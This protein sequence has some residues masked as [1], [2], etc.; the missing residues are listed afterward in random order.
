M[1]KL[2]SEKSVCHGF[3][4]TETIDFCK[5]MLLLVDRLGDTPTQFISVLLVTKCINLT[6]IYSDPIFAQDKIAAISRVPGI[7]LQLTNSLLCP[8]G[9]ARD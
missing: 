1:A 9:R 7:H 3:R 5:R 6:V 2:T 4:E 8:N